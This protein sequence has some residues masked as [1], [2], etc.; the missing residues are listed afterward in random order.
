MTFAVLL[1]AAIAAAVPRT[2]QVRIDGAV[3]N[4]GDGLLLGNGDLSCSVYQDKDALVF[5]F[6]KGDVWDRRFYAN[7][8]GQDAEPAHIE[9]YR[10]GVLDEGWKG[11]YDRGISS[12]RP[13]KD[14]RRMAEVLTTPARYRHPLPVIKPVGEFRLR[15]P[16]PAF[17]GAAPKLTQTLFVEEGRV[18]VVYAYPNGVT[19]TVEAVIDPVENVLSASWRIDGWTD[20]TAYG[21]IHRG[22][23]LAAGHV[24][25]HGHRVCA[26]KQGHPCS[27]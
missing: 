15:V 12:A 10:R 6:G 20:W 16:E 26:Q 8:D 27:V 13:P 4:P 18:E 3:G 5:R 2:H 25:L 7:A 19:T 11:S 9:E 1:A 22:V 24:S 14:P 23:H 17:M 21:G